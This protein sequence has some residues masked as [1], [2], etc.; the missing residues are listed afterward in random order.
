M[1]PSALIPSLSPS[2]RLYK[3]LSSAPLFSLGC[4]A[5]DFVGSQ[6]AI[7]EG[8]EQDSIDGLI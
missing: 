1:F 5:V 4:C 3:C 2:S 6:L 7:Q 8:L